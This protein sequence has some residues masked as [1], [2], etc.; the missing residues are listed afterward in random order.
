MVS[1]AGGWPATTLALAKAGALIISRSL[2]AISMGPK[3]RPRPRQLRLPQQPQRGRVQGLRLYQELVRHRIRARNF[4]R[5]ADA[6]N[7]AGRPSSS[8]ELDFKCS[9][10]L[11][12]NAASL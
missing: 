12:I 9:L 7:A 2:S 6:K 4:P 3:P 10:A 1:C 5:F 8:S 11:V